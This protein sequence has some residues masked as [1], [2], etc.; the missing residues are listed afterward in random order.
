MSNKTLIQ[1]L[2]S[3]HLI[4]EQSG[5]TGWITFNDPAK[6]NAVSLAMWEGIPPALER[7]EKD[8][9]IRSVV[10]TGAGGKAF[11]SGANISQFDQ[12]RT[13]RDA[14]E[15]YEQAAEGAQLALQNFPKPLIA[16]IDGYCIGG[17]MNIALCCDIRFASEPSSMSIP[18]ARLGLGYRFSAIQNLVRAVGA[19][20]ALD[21]FLSAERYTATRAKELGLVQYVVAKDELDQAVTGYLDKINANAPL[22]MAAGKLMIKQITDRSVTLDEQ[23]MKRLVIECFDSDDYKEG[24]LAF[25]EKRQPVF[26]GK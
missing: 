23:E 13:G 18:A 8:S 14:V 25:S 4:V 12:L 26:Q 20:N 21:I 2:T 3:E 7:F 1:E 17:G 5:Q 15:Y 22:T 11:V 19:A 16:R 10:I 9:N 24:K 6:H